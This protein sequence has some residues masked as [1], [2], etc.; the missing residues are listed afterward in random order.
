[1]VAWALKSYASLFTGYQR[2]KRAALRLVDSL[3]TLP[4]DVTSP[5]SDTIYGWIEGLCATPH[6][7]AGTPEGHRAE[8]YVADMFA[9]FGL[10]RITKEPIE[11]T[12]WDPHRWS[13]TV[14]GPPGEAVE[15]PC[16][17]VVNTEFTGPQ[18]VTA[19]MVFVPRPWLPGALRTK[20]VKGKIVVADVPFPNIPAASESEKLRSPRAGRGTITSRSWQ[21]RRHHGT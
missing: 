16:F 10:E 3:P 6:R 5:D 20:N 2:Q 8:D 18:G 12:V 21:W 4:L 9:R 13:L 11:M 14:T 1:M 7:R 15:I 17:G 19:P